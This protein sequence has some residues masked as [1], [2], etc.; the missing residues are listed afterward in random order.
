MAPVP[1]AVSATTSPSVVNAQRICAL[2]SMRTP[3]ASSVRWWSWGLVRAS[4]ALG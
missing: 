4:L 1:L 2:T 3:F